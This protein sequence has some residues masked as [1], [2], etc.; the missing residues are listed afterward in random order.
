MNCRGQA[1]GTT[2]CPAQPQPHQNGTHRDKLNVTGI[3]NI[4]YILQ[5]VSTSSSFSCLPPEA[6]L[7]GESLGG[8]CPKTRNVKAVVHYS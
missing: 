6:F 5:C 1:G 3:G 7:K 2:P 4:T 8:S